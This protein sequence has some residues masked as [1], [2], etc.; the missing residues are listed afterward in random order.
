MYCFSSFF[1]FSICIYLFIF[2]GFK[3]SCFLREQSNN[4]E[5]SDLT[6]FDFLRYKIFKAKKE[7]IF[8]NYW[9]GR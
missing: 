6:L 2:D 7:I 1:L 9:I 8:L 5:S 4:V 3:K